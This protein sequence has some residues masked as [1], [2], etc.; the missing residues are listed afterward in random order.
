MDLRNLVDRHRGLLSFG[1]LA[2]ALGSGA[3]WLTQR[4]AAY[5]VAP[6]ALDTQALEALQTMRTENDALTAELTALKDRVAA[7]TSAPAALESG[8]VAGVTDP[9]R[10]TLKTATTQSGRVNLNSATQAQLEDLPGIGPSKATA[11]L[12]YRADH[13]PFHYPHDLVNVKGIG[14]KTYEG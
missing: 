10:S 12:D 13:G 7:A 11:I 9:P 3:L 4:S 2:V 1:L 6:P 14:E 5:P 8:S